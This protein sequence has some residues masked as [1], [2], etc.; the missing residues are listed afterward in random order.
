MIISKE[1]THE[2]N[3]NYE[4]LG[5]HHPKVKIGVDEV[6]K[7]IDEDKITLNS[8]PIEKRKWPKEYQR[9]Y[10]INNLW[11]YELPEYYR[12]IYTVVTKYPRKIYRLF[13]VL[14]HPEYNKLF[15]YD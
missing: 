11:R 9:I 10:K 7:L 14:S 13:N 8:N 6:K 12:L 15:G 3:K 2:F 4:K 1:A 5:K